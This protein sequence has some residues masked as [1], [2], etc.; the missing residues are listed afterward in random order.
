MTKAVLWGARLYNGILYLNR[1]YRAQ[2][3]FW[4]SHTFLKYTKTFYLRIYI[5]HFGQIV[6]LIFKFL[7][8]LRLYILILVYCILHFLTRT[9]CLPAYYQD[10]CWV[11]LKI[12]NLFLIIY[13]VVTAINGFVFEKV[14]WKLLSLMSVFLRGRG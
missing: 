7:L 11:K 5:S 1:I 13:T 14:T 4:T 8:L 6:I 3:R 9:Y 2:Q 10:F 12:Q